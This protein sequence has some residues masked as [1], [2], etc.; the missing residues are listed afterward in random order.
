MKKYLGSENIRFFRHSGY[1]KLPEVIPLST[2]QAMRAVISS[3]MEDRVPPYIA[4]ETGSVIRLSELYQRDPIF[5]EVFMSPIV[6]DPLESLLGPNIELVLNRH[7]HATINRPGIAAR[8]LHRDVLQWTRDIITVV[9]YLEN[10]TVE[11]GC[12]LV[13]PGSQFLPFVGTPNNGGTWM[14][15]HSV[16]QSLIDQA[17]PVPMP[18]GGL[19]VLDSLMFHACGPNHS[20]E[21]RMAVTMGFH[22]VDELLDDPEPPHRI[23]MRGERLYRGNDRFI[24]SNNLLGTP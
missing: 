2:V 6:L 4:D 24:D 17:L 13:I 21:D 11:N 9:L 1:L 8:R 19:L 16:Y 23:L 3:Y 10:S 15:E 14:D 12:T 18:A 7:N 20:H 5:A 22:S